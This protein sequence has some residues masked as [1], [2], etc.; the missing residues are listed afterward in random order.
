MLGKSRS[1]GARHLTAGTCR[2]FI[3]LARK[4]WKYIN[5]ITIFISCI[6]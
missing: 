1:A 4:R 2:R 5:V 3:F 6:F